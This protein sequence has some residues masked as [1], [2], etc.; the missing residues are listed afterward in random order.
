[1]TIEM[2]GSSR[3]FIV[4]TMDPDAALYLAEKLLPDAGKR[5]FDALTCSALSELA[6][7]ISGAAATLIYQFDTTVDISTPSFYHN[8]GPM[9][10]AFIP[11]DTQ[12]VCMPIVLEDGSIFEIDVMLI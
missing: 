10:F 8:A 9:E 1:M 6:N 5:S 4:Y 7:M 2:Y 12:V 11:F 3:G